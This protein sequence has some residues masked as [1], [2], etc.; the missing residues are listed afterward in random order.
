M[1]N[2]T[3]TLDLLNNTETHKIDHLRCP[4]PIATCSHLEQA[5]L[6]TIED[7]VKLAI[8]GVEMDQSMGL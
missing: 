6:E 5:T 8:N 3:T 1:G 2:L 4:C 7:K